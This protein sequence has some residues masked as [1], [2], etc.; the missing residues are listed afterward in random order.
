VVVD[1]RG[2]EGEGGKGGE[3]DEIEKA[4]V[5]EAIAGTST[6]TCKHGQK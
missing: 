1:E 5:R 2:G 3:E 6:T 4:A